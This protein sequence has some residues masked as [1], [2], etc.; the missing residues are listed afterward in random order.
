PEALADIYAVGCAL[1]AVL[2]GTLPFAGGTVEQ[3]LARHLSE[4][5]KPLET[6]GIPQPLAQLVTYLMAKNPGVRYQSAAIV[7]EQLGMFV[8][9]PAIRIKSPTEAPTLG[10]YEEVLAKRAPVK[11]VRGQKSEVVGT[12][13]P[14]PVP[15]AGEG[16]G[17]AMPPVV[18]LNVSPPSRATT[19]AEILRRRKAQQKRNMLVVAVLAGLV[20]IV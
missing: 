8:E 2:A 17:A 15:A 13:P 20:L 16:F 1:Y 9:P 10:A 18:N 6:F 7:A 11:E 12:P 19:A 14:L 5:I 3:K 4:P